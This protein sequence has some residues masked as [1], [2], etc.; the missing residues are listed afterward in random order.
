[1]AM[2]MLLVAS[3]GLSGSSS[4]GGLGLL[5][6]AG[7]CSGLLLEPQASSSEFSPAAR[8]CAVR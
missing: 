4:F 5:S 8:P 3:I 1:M 6:R 2:P 7:R